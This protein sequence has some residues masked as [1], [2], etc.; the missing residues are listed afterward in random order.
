MPLAAPVRVLQVA[1]KQV[2]EV[3]MMTRSGSSKANG[4][5]ANGS[6]AKNEVL[7]MLKQDH[8]RAKKAFSDF[9]KLGSG[10]EER[11]EAIVERTCAE[12]EVHATLEECS[13]GART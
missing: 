12:L 3:P 4:S 13:S 1:A 2:Q 9:E 7:D 5:K 10:D 8:K 11:S 6:K